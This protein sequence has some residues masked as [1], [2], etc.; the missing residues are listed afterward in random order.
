MPSKERLKVQFVED[1]LLSRTEESDLAPKTI[2]KYRVVLTKAINALDIA[3]M[4]YNPRK[5][6]KEEILF[7]RKNVFKGNSKEYNRWQLAVFGSWLKWHSN[8]S[9][10]RMKIPWPQGN[11]VNDGWLTPEQSIA[12]KRAASGIEKLVVHLEMGLGLRRI[13]MYRL[14]VSD[15]RDGYISVLGK[16]RNG[17]KL[18]PVSW[19]DETP[20][21]MEDYYR[22][23]AELIEKARKFN[24]R[25][26]EPSGLLIYQKG[27]TLGQYQLT[28]IDYIVT[29]VGKKANIPKK[30]TNHMLRRTCGRLLHKSGVPI[31]EITVILR[32]E[33]PKTTLRYLG[34]TLD[35][36]KE[37]FA[38]RGA[39]LKNIEEGMKTDFS[40]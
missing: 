23:R 4:N 9:L 17:G 7:L 24:P 13:D 6:G 37:A 33:N 21:I 28:A 34:I 11:S 2:S 26:K 40:K 3:G 19:D 15:V 16:G 5:M 20:A 25:A 30:V 31:E 35:D 8:N 22:L 18:R 32:H 38:K 39:F 1:F 36:Q 29:R 27:G 12:M 10:D 14:T